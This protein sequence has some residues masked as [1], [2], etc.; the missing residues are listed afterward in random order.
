ML[1]H[2][3][4]EGKGGRHGEGAGVGRRRSQCLGAGRNRRSPALAR[5]RKSSNSSSS[6]VTCGP[7]PRSALG[8]CIAGWTRLA[9]RSACPAVAGGQAV[10]ASVRPRRRKSGRAVTR[11]I[12]DRLLASDLRLRPFGRRALRRHPDRRLRLRRPAAQRRCGA[13]SS[14]GSGVAPCSLRSRG[15]E[16]RRPAL[17]RHP[18]R[19]QQ[20]NGRR[21]R[22]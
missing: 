19:S 7:V 21:R 16:F 2:L 9:L 18:A 1:K 4:S 22:R 15:P 10:C 13:A 11:D 12:L 6:P 14:A 20:E 17:S 8:G 5:D 3:G